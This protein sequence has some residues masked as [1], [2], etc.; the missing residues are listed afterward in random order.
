[1]RAR[2]DLSSTVGALFFVMDPLVK[3][4]PDQPAKPMDNRADG[5]IE[6][7]T[8]HGLKQITASLIPRHLF[9]KS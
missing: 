3:N 1:M 8:G 5:L 9:R 7:E 4:H 6:F 2:F